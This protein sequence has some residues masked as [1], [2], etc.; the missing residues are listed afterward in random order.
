MVLKVGKLLFYWED[1]VVSSGGGSVLGFGFGWIV[2]EF[3]VGYVI[4]SGGEG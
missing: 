4:C 2:W 3:A 1:S